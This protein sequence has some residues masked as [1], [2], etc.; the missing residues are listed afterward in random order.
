MIT[1]YDDM[2][3]SI[4]KIL[5]V[6]ASH[7]S[8]YAAQRI[9]ELEGDNKRLQAE[10]NAA[11][12]EAKAQRRRAREAEAVLDKLPKT[13]DGAHAVPGMDLFASRPMDDETCPLHVEI[14][15]ACITREGQSI[16]D[17][18]EDYFSTREAADSK[19]TE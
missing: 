5:R 18:V 7:P 16:V 10:L 9:E 19:G 12:Q 4:V 11:L 13:K 1:T 15:A 2:N 14:R 17:G 6:G 3:K 8:L